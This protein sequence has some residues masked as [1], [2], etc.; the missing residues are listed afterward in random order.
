MCC[1]C[2]C[3][4]VCVVCQVTFI[5]IA[6]LTI[7]IVNKARVCVGECERGCM[8]VCVCVYL[9]GRHSLSLILSK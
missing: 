9:R 2:A 5:Y 6:L 1:V 8:S 3:V 7:Q 4:V